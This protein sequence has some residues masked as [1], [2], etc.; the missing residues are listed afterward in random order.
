MEDHPAVDPLPAVPVRLEPEMGHEKVAAKALCE[1]VAT[2]RDS[3]AYLHYFCAQESG[4]ADQL[5]DNEPKRV[6]LYQCVAALLR[7]Y[8]N[9][10]SEL[11]EAGYP[12][13]EIVKI[14]DEVDHFANVRDEVR[15]A[16]GDYIDLKI[17]AD[18]TIT[19]WPK[20][21][22]VSAFFDND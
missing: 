6:K 9:I 8:A 13:S 20:K 22:D 3:A 5:K 14:K 12:P 16:S 11:A 18:G 10:A 4:N 7:A 1:P 21:P 19:N 15:L 2:P 17:A